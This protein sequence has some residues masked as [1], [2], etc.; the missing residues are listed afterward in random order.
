MSTVVPRFGRFHV[1]NVTCTS[2]RVAN[3]SFRDQ[4]VHRLRY[5]KQLRDLVMRV[6][7]CNSTGVPTLREDLLGHQ[8]AEI[9]E[10]DWAAF[11]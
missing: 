7:K 11:S 1:K 6:L 2:R 9:C 3:T 4:I 8:T 10:M 5:S